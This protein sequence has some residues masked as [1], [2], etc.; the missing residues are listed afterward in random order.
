MIDFEGPLRPS[1]SR[2]L[3]TILLVALVT[4]GCVFDESNQPPM[5]SGLP[6][7]LSLKV[8]ESIVIEP[9]AVDP[10][11]DALSFEIANQ[12]GW[13]T[14]D[15]DSG[16]L[17]GTPGDG[18]VGTYA[19]VRISVTDGKTLVQGDAFSVVVNAPPAAE[20]PP[21]APPPP[22]APTPPPP[23]PTPPPPPPPP[24]NQAPRIS[25][26]P[27][28][29]V[30]E[31]QAYA[32]TPSASDPNG[33]AITFSISNKPSWASFSTGTGRL[34]GTP[35]RGDVGAH[36]G[37]AISV[38]DGKATATLPPFEITVIAANRAPT[39]GGTP[40]GS[41]TEGQAYSF[42]PTASDPDGDTLAFSIRNKPAWA[43]FSTANGTLSG[44][45]AAGTAGSYANI[46]ISV[47]D[48]KAQASLPAFGITV[49]QVATGS[50]TLSWTPPTTRTDGSPL[51]NLAGYKVH[52]GTSQ[53]SYPNT[54]TINNP[55]VTTYVVEN[56]SPA[57]WYFVTT[58]FDD[59]G[60][61]SDY[62]N[63][64]SKTIR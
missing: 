20:P 31:G 50:A 3:V 40:A 39:I 17:S 29:M 19:G 10:D 9:L 12:P 7:D 27:A 52:Y 49:Q 46:A 33:D 36:V 16:V 8:G 47:S 4:T 56:L 37:I 64:A 25:G 53:G 44:T 30:T 32:F 51:T 38:S 23:A 15:P 21:V 61:E 24:S 63:V 35:A 11:G 41:A 59:T 58:A 2:N 43:S 13:S 1:L 57:T 26:T 60:G 34:S 55:G 14:F 5:L 48:G 54:I 62:S 6:G 28:P 22:P 45:P 42:R 18:D